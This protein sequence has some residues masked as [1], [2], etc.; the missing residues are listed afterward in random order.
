MLENSTILHGNMFLLSNHYIKN[1]NDF[2]KVAIDTV[3]KLI[4]LSH[5]YKWLIWKMYPIVNNVYYHFVGW[6]NY[7]Y[8]SCKSR[9]F[10]QLC[11]WQLFDLKSLTYVWSSHILKF[12]FWIIQ[13]KSDKEMTKIKVVDLDDFYNFI[14][15]NVF[16]WNQLLSQ[17][18]IRIFI[19]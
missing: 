6:R 11:C 15:D 19:F 2:N 17:N 14:V 10:V 18:S 1:S 16:I 12:K 9:W 4:H 3:H 13:T 7:Q 5:S 8:K